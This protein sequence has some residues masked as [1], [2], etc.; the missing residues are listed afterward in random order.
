ML[1]VEEDGQEVSVCEAGLDQRE[2][3]L[4][5]ARARA[6]P[7]PKISCWDGLNLQ[8][9]CKDMKL[10]EPTACYCGTSWSSG[11]WSLDVWS[12]CSV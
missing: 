1:K 11:G 8:M 9:K 3:L 10:S 4:S 12:L 2:A 5:L 7:C 6:R